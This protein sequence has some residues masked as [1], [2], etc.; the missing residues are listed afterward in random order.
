MRIARRREFRRVFDQGRRASDDL[1]RIWV[2]P[3]DA[4]RTRLGI[5]VGKRHGNAVQR[6]RFRRMI[7]EAFRLSRDDL[8]A[9][10]DVVCIPRENA[11]PRLARCRASLIRLVAKAASAFAT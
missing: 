4:A 9:G 3:N 8:P 10:I 5:S 11:I 6:N 2:T 1:L 7:R